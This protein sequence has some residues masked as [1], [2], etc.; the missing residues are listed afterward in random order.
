MAQFE[1]RIQKL[2][3][4]SGAGSEIAMAW[5][6]VPADMPEEA[7]LEATEELASAHGVWVGNVICTTYE[8]NGF[9]PPPQMLTGDEVSGDRVVGIRGGKLPVGPANAEQTVSEC[10]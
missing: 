3:Q 8:G 6:P 10:R 4:K 9:L 1:R 7:R 2:E 5:F